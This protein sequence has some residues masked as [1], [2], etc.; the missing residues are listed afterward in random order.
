ME[1]LRASNREKDSA[2]QR[3]KARL[4]GVEEAFEN[5]YRLSDDT[6]ARLKQ[7]SKMFR[8]VSASVGA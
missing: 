3:L 8:D 1:E 6:E 5:A 7:E 4:Q 2:I